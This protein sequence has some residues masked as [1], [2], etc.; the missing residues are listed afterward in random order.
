MNYTASWLLLHFLNVRACVRHYS[1]DQRNPIHDSIVGEPSW[2][3]MG[4]Y[5]EASCLV[6]DCV[7]LL[8]VGDSVSGEAVLGL[9]LVWAWWSRY[10]SV[11]CWI[12]C[13][14]MSLLMT[15]PIPSYS[16]RAAASKISASALAEAA[17]AAAAAFSSFSAYSVA[18]SKS[19]LALCFFNSNSFCPYV[20]LVCAASAAALASASTDAACSWLECV[21]WA[22]MTAAGE[23]LMI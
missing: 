3:W 2:Q 1:R 18:F 23:S 20:T 13:G 22:S 9:K 15:L 5:S 21:V 19:N 7:F 10:A 8:C 4:L 17:A 6:S 14:E 12:T 11:H 16:D